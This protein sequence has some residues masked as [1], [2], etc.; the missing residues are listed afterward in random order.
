LTDS[1]SAGSLELDSFFCAPSSVPAW[2]AIA[3]KI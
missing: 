2:L 3:T 1:A